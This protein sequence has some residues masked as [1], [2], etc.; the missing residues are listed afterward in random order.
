VISVILCVRDAASTMQRQL[1]ALAAQVCDVEW[2]LVVVDNGS[3]DGTPLMAASMRDRVPNLRIVD[4]S[5]KVGLAHSRNVG[6]RAAQGELLLFCDGD[7]EVE[8]GWIT[9]MAQAAEAADILGGALDR[10][11]L[12]DPRWLTP[13]RR[14]TDALQAW[15]GFLAFPSGANCG[16]RAAVFGELGGFEESYLCGTED[17]QFFWRAQLAGFTVR[18]VPAAVVHYRERG[19]LRDVARQFYGYGVQHPH[20]FRDFRDQGMPPS[21]WKQT[22]RV[23]AHLFIYAPR[24]WS[25]T[26]GRRAWV[27]LASR[28]AARV[29]GSLRWR[30]LYL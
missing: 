18:F 14:R 10:T 12:N 3:T 1:D 5:D 30:V 20:L 8:S 24:Y 19:R 27:R 13:D 2:E 28:C 21:R 22:L 6:C 4:A 11:R 25:S 17:T 9:A 29:V 7:D 15:P 26:P 16:M 23:W